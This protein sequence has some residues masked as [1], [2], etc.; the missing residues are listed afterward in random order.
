M[1][2]AIVCLVLFTALTATAQNTPECR[3]LLGIF[4]SE[5]VDPGSLADGDVSY[6]GGPGQTMVYVVLL[7]PHNEHTDQPITTVGG[8]EIG[9]DWPAA[10]FVHISLGMG[11]PEVPWPDVV[12]GGNGPVV[13]GQAVL[14]SIQAGFFTTAPEE[15]FLRPVATPTFAGHM[16]IVDF[17]DGSASPAHPIS[18]DYAAP[19]F[20]FYTTPGPWDDC[21]G[22]VPGEKTAWGDVKAIYR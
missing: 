2:F 15:V 17:A 13:G 22:V 11:I 14:F 21:A 9:F 8:F 18:H 6:W 5:S 1:K 16:A 12:W 7:Y 3:N 4:T 19:V 20:G 10:H